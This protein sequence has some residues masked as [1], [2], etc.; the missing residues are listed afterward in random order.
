MMTAIAALLFHGEVEL[1][2]AEAV[3]LATQAS[4]LIWDNLIHG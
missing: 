3:I 4:L 2:R 1:D